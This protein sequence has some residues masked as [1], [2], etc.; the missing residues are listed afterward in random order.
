[1]STRRNRLKNLEQAAAE[2]AVESDEEPRVA[3]KSRLVVAEEHAQFYRRKL[4][5]RSLSPDERQAIESLIAQYDSLAADFR[6]RG[7]W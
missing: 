7:G 4:A 1:M 2:K 6:V 3:G 5:N